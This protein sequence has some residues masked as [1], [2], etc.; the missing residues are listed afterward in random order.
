M[1]LFNDAQREALT[2]LVT[3]AKLI[4]L[5]TDDFETEIREAMLDVADAIIDKGVAACLEFLIE[6]EGAPS[7]ERLLN[8]KETIIKEKEAAQRAR[9]QDLT[10]RETEEEC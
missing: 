7:V 1:R 4:G 3:R 8:E 10:P 2:K 9:F 5:E 6:N